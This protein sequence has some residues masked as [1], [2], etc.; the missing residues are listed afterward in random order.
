MKTK[1]IFNY[2][3][4]TLLFFGTTKSSGQQIFD[5]YEGVPGDNYGR[6]MGISGDGQW[7][8]I[9]RSPGSTGNARFDVFSKLGN[10][11][12]HVQE[13]LTTANIHFDDFQLSTDGKRLATIKGAGFSRPGQVQM[14]E[15][16]NGQY[17]KIG[18]TIR[19]ENTG[20]AFGN[21]G[22]AFSFSKDG[23]TVA[24]GTH[25]YDQPSE[26]GMVEIY[27]YD[28]T[29]WVAKGDRIYGDNGQ[30]IGSGVGLSE[31]GQRVAISNNK[32]GELETRVMEWRQGSWELLGN[33]INNYA[34]QV[35]LTKNGT[36]LVAQS[37]A[38]SQ[39]FDLQNNNWMPVMAAIDH[40]ETV[41]GLTSEPWSFDMT[42]DGEHI[43]CGAKSYVMRYDVV[44]GDWVR[45]DGPFYNEDFE[46][47]Y[48]FGLCWS[49]DARTML[50]NQFQWNGL[51][52][53]VFC[54]YDSQGSGISIRPFFDKNGNGVRDAGEE[55]VT[56][57]TIEVDGSYML[58]P[59]PD[60]AYYISAPRGQHSLL[61]FSSDG[62]YIYED[63]ELVVYSIPGS[64]REYDLPLVG[65][66][67]FPL[68]VTAT[69]DSYLCNSN[70]EFSIG[71]SNLNTSPT[72]LIVELH[73]QPLNAGGNVIGTWTRALEPCG[74]LIIDTTIIMPSETSVGEM[75]SYVFVV[76]EVNAAGDVMDT[77]IRDRSAILLCA[78]DPNDKQVF[79]AGRPGD[80]WTL[81]DQVFS[82]KIRF[83]NTGN[84][85]ATNI[86]IKDQLDPNLNSETFRVTN[87]SHKLTAVEMDFNSE[88]KFIFNNIN[89]PDSINNEPMSHG[90]VEYE[91]EPWEGLPDFAEVKNQ[92]EIYFDLNAPI[93]TNETRNV[94]VT[95]F[96]VDKTVEIKDIEEIKVFPNPT[97]GQ[98][99]LDPDLGVKNYVVINQQGQQVLK[100]GVG[101]NRIDVENL[102]AQ[103]YWILLSTEDGV[104][105][106][107]FIK[108]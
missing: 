79:P 36:R 97:N 16:Q 74:E 55:D 47:Y 12:E 29:E 20:D 95:S 57:V 53:R 99:F 43:I 34:G 23:N 87:S 25:D 100:G 103:V 37:R 35:R 42:P 51:A 21:S 48:G 108:Q 85:P 28:G 1:R 15:L 14:Y 63:G 88:V 93:I 82:Y 91:I 89:L 49:D 61:I 4:L 7:M 59:G 92:A 73:D 5:Y 11:F 9:S 52:S 102:A 33:F 69:N 101:S 18:S 71:V 24:I 98:I 17:V 45:R 13:V 86:Y 66:G 8:V 60:G 40:S 96:G 107:R 77:Q 50:I 64:V 70:A 10:K 104:K 2:L 76:K 72:D 78:Y 75:L 106:A 32:F 38:T 39:V 68:D 19:E 44:G 27:E 94:L 31:D 105:K 26:N 56:D 3:F 81:K 30:K 58:I 6:A 46:L 67:N 65:T 84:L 22:Y 83:Q 54:M 41:P 90:F 62:R 80:D